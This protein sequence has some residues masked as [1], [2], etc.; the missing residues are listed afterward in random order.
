MWNVERKYR[1]KNGKSW[2]S[3]GEQG[4]GIG[5]YMPSLL[6]ETINFIILPFTRAHNKWIFSPRYFE[7]DVF[8]SQSNKNV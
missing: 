6:L 3:F 1:E 2:A 4:I 8:T 7:F 5:R